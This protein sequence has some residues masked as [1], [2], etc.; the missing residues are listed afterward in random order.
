VGS[1]HPEAGCQGLSSYHQAWQEFP[2]QPDS[3]GNSTVVIKQALEDLNLRL[4][5]LFIL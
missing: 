3:W 4:T 2:Q 1:L 5:D